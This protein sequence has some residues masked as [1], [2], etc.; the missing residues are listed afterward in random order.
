MTPTVTCEGDKETIAVR[1]GKRKGQRWP[2]PVHL[3]NETPK[4][5]EQQ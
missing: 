2:F 4:K 3:H 1:Q 5:F